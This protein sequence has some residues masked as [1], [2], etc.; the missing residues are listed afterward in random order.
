MSRRIPGTVSPER[1]YALWADAYDVEN[2]V[3]TL[4]Q[5]AAQDLTPDLTAKSL[6]DAGCGTGRRLPS[7]GAG[8]PKQAVGVD[9]VRAM[10][11]AGRRQDA[12]LVNADVLGLPMASGA[13]DVVWCRLVLGHVPDL[14][15]AY[16][17]LRRVM[18]RAGTLIVTDFHTDAA[19]AGH[20]RTFED[21]TDR[22]YAIAFEP[23][24]A[25]EH[26]TAAR[27]AG[28]D[29][30]TRRDLPIGPAV[31]S[32]Y[33]EAGALDRYQADAGLPLVLALRFRATPV[34]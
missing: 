17:E 10:L 28:L 23:H 6:L 15:R 30:E 11:R 29:L 13:F 9:L 16:R 7:P 34:A 26:V 20:H 22:R 21:A 3:T 18:H 1:G 2:A 32:F 8:G 14:H 19:T 33:R 4:D 27:K 5:L 31:R 25:D 24:A 12:H